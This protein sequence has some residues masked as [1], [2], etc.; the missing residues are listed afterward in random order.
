ML[1][2]LDTV[3]DM[4]ARVPRL[5]HNV[6]PTKD[7]TQCGQTALL[8]SDLRSRRCDS[9]GVVTTRASRTFS[10]NSTTFKNVSKY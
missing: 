7:H 3:L 6:L 4:S 8:N 5:L 9:P 1:Q 2:L 10:E